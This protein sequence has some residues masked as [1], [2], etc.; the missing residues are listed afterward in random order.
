MVEAADR[1]RGLFDGA[2][3]GFSTLKDGRPI[4]AI[5]YGPATGPSKTALKQLRCRTML[6]HAWSLFNED[7][8]SLLLMVVLKNVPITRYAGLAGVSPAFV[9]Q[10]LVEALD[11]LIEWFNIEV[12]RG[13]A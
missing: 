11:R 8:R 5:R 3:L 1:L 4:S 12:V 10:Q 6:G 2:R 13:A 9:K 7:T